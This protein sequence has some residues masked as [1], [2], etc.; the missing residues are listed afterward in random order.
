MVHVLDNFVVVL[1]LGSSTA[2]VAFTLG[3]KSWRVAVARRL[4]Q[5]AP[6]LPTRWGLRRAA[7]RLSTLATK[8]A[9]GACGACDNCGS[10]SAG[11]SA[12]GAG[13]GAGAGVS[14]AGEVRI[15]VAK[16]GRRR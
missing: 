14:M 2:Y 7:L 8:K 4:G 15:A 10:E 12:S 11:K 5:F 13:A 9:G 3:P 6:R 1:V 16:I